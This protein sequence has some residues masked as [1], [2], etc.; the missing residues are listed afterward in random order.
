[1]DECHAS[2]VKNGQKIYVQLRIYQNRPFMMNCCMYCQWS[3]YLLGISL[4]ANRCVATPLHS[5]LG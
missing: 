5:V 4:Q 2:I 3:S 1:M